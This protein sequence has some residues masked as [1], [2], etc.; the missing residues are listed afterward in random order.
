[1]KFNRRADRFLRRGLSA[2][3]CEWR[4]LAAT[5]N[6]LK[7][8]RARLA[9][10]AAGMALARPPDGARRRVRPPREH[11]QSRMTSLARTRKPRSEA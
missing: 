6:L 9:A 1:V 4:L 5:H 2:C 10:N 7:L 8:W 11:E 3:N